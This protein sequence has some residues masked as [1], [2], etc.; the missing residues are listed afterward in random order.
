MR[1]SNS[2]VRHTIVVSKITIMTLGSVRDH[3]PML[4]SLIKWKPKNRRAVLA[5][6]DKKLVCVICEMIQNVMNGHVKLSPKQFQKLKN[7]KHILRKIID[8]RTNLAMKRKLLSQKGAG[9]LSLLVPAIATIV[10]G[11][12]S[13]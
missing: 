2:I 10:S 12:F 7:H 6:A 11:I 1:W 3:M 13:R 4:R 9:F 5:N 8:K